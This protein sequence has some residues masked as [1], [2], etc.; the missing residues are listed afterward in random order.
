MQV[1]PRYSPAEL[2]RLAGDLHKRCEEIAA[3]HALHVWEPV[4]SVS[5]LLRLGGQD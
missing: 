4:P 3:D 1:I 5:D 2:E